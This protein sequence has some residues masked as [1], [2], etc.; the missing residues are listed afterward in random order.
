MHSAIYFNVNQNRIFRVLSFVTIEDFLFAFRSLCQSVDRI[1]TTTQL[2]DE[3]SLSV[4]LGSGRYGI[5]KHGDAFVTSRVGSVESIR[6]T[7]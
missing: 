4:E 1:I 5:G 3:H 2:V 6:A 7:E